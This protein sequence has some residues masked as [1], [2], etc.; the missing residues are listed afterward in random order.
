MSGGGGRGGGP[1]NGNDVMTLPGAARCVPS[2]YELSDVDGD[3]ATASAP[4][5]KLKLAL[6][7]RRAKKV[8][9][10]YDEKPPILL[11]GLRAATVEATFPFS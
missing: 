5:V 3:R 11:R 1:S 9:R 6:L 4:I 7:R 10:V 8:R 2:G